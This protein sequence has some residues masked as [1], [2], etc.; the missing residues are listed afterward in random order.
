MQLPRNLEDAIRELASLSPSL[1]S[2]FFCVG[3]VLGLIFHPG[4]EA[5]A[6]S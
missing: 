2:A 3:S 1:D 5:V 4:V 6:T